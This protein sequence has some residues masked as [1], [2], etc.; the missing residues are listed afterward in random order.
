MT[1]EETLRRGGHLYV[2]FLTSML[3]AF[4]GGMTAMPLVEK[5]LV[6][7][8]HYMT[9]DEFWTYP[10]IGQTLP[11]VVGIHNAMLIGNR[12]AG[13]FGGFMAALG[14]ITTAFGCMLIIGGLF[15]SFI[16]NPF[17]YGAISGI[18]VISVVILSDITVKMFR[19]CQK[20][21]LTYVLIALGFVLPAF[22]NFSAFSVILIAGAAGI[23]SAYLMKEE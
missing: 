21:S 22:F 10:A 12:V 4:T 2:L 17:V 14:V 5:D 8:Y 19:N 3:T 23:G 6:D 13:F 15:Q 11:G 18:R 16:T 20:G 9:D 1:R 7:K